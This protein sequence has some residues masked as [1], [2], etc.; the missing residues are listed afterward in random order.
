MPI[1]KTSTDPTTLHRELKIE[2]CLVLDAQPD[3]HG[4]DRGSSLRSADGFVVL[5]FRAISGPTVLVDYF[6]LYERHAAVMGGHAHGLP[7]NLSE[8]RLFRLAL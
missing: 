7:S 8:F 1:T 3:S 4:F 5:S 6:G 2:N